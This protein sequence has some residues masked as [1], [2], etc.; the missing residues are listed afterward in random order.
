MVPEPEKYVP[1][2][3]DKVCWLG[4]AAD[5]AE[6]VGVDDLFVW[7]RIDGDEYHTVWAHELLP[8][9]EPVVYPERW[10][11]VYR[12]YTGGWH[13]DPGDLWAMRSSGC[14]GVLHLFPDG[15]T[16]MEAP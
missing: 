7:C 1:K 10:C 15:H 14:I 3:G 4:R 9:V 6:V 2:V 13:A 16:E 8:Y 11:N 5:Y 12:D